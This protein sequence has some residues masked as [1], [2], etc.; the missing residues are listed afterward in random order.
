MP[1]HPG[2]RPREGGSSGLLRPRRSGSSSA[3]PGTGPEATAVVAGNEVGITG[4]RTCALPLCSAHLCAASSA[5]TWKFPGGGDRYAFLGVKG[6]PVQIRPSRRVFRTLVPRSGNE[7]GHAH[8]HLTGRN[9]QNI[10]GGR[11]AILLIA[12]WDERRPLTT[13]RLQ[14]LGHRTRPARDPRCSAHE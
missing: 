1:W 12:R 2:G 5:E 8:S 10:Q 7:T 4:A 6:S 13:A 11:R 14:L 3:V 9:E